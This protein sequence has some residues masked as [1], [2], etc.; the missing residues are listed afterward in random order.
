M[1]KYLH[2]RCVEKKW[3]EEFGDETGA[4]PDES[5]LGVAIRSPDGTHYSMEPS[6]VD[7]DFLE[8]LRL[9]D[10]TVGLTMSS[11][12]TESLFAQVSPFQEDLQL[13]PRLRIPVVQSLEQIITSNVEIDHNA[14]A[15]L[16][17][18][19][20][21]VM[22][23]NDTVE[24]ILAHGAIVEDK[25]MGHVRLG[26]D[27]CHSSCSQLYTGLGVSNCNSSH[28]TFL[29]V[30]TSNTNNVPTGCLNSKFGFTDG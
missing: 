23:W 25:L 18:E 13:G 10:A 8:A 1:V 19:E 30:A 5:A 24:G 7:A 20:R 9:L 28:A 21:I 29:P 27:I 12:I 26:T 22:L 6:T 14:F 4:I 11:E 3:L 16:L 17:R 2:Q 15:C